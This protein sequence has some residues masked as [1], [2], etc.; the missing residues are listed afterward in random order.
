MVAFSLASAAVTTSNGKRKP[1]GYC[2][3]NGYIHS[4]LS[5]CKLVNVDCDVTGNAFL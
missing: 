4:P 2:I 3:I 1:N 5:S